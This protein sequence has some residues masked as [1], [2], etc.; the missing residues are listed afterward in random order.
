MDHLNVVEPGCVGTTVG[1]YVFIALLSFSYQVQELVRFR[2]G[3]PTS[4]D[5]DIVFTHANATS[6]K[7][8][9]A[10]LVKRLRSEGLVTHVMRKYRLAFASLPT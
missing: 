5:I 10:R 6:A 3:K 8:L 2:R 4:N 7:G 9:C 1:G